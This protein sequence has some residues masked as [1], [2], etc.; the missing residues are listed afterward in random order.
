MRLTSLCVKRSGKILVSPASCGAPP[1]RL[2][3]LIMHPVSTLLPQKF[4]KMD[5]EEDS[6]TGKHGGDCREVPPHADLLEF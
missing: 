2:L 3:A 5:A 6:V 1:K 4:R